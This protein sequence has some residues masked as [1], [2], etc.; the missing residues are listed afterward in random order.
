MNFSA[1]PGYESLYEV[2]ECGQVRSLD[3][4]L[5]G[6]DGIQYSRKG[7][8]LKQSPHKDVE[9]LQVSLWKENLGTSFYTHRLVAKAH[10]VNPLNLPEVNHKNGI[11][12]DNRV[13]NLEWV[14]QVDN[15]RHAIATGLKIYTNRLTKLEFIECL[16]AVIDGETY[17]SL[18]KRVPY[19]VPFLSTKVRSIA[20][21]LGLEGELDASLMEQRI[22]R[23]RINGAKNY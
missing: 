1:I 4:V 8:I 2:S 17:A 15:I 20:R 10:I 7:R 13:E 16:E 11:R 9:Y 3:R 12:I 21:E 18:T 22:I 23:A 6:K 5:L 19:K 14:S